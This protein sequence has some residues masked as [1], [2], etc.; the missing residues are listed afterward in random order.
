MDIQI[1]TIF[2]LCEELLQV[3]KPKNLLCKVSDAEI[4]TTAVCATLFFGGNFERASAFLQMSGA[5]PIRLSRSQFNRR[6]HGLKPQFVLLC[7]ILGQAWKQQNREATYAIDTFPVP[8]CDNIR[9]RR[10]RLYQGEAFRGYT[11]SKR[12]YFYGLKIHL[13]ITTKG[14][15]VELFFTPGSVG[16]V[17]GLQIFSFDLQKG[18]TVYA[19]KAYNDYTLEDLLEEACGIH[20]MPLRK[21]NS[22]RPFPAYIQFVQQH[23]RKMVETA[24][25]LLE[26]LLPKHIHAV[27]SKGFELKLVLFVLAYSISTLFHTT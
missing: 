1:I 10:A 27:T 9:I 23:Q 13:M 26:R 20:L 6:V 21:K 7:E 17:D 18:S 16:D 12:R 8:A 4:M 19:D 11:P 25:S 2:V 14:Q 3:S 15:P 22:K 5:I 24:G